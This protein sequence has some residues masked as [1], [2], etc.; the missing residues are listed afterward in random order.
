MLDEPTSNLDAQTALAINTTLRSLALNRTIIA[1][2]HDLSSVADADKI[3]VLQD[4]HL[5][6]EGIY[7]MLLMEE[8]VYNQL[9]Q[10]QG[11]AVQ[12]NGLVNGNIRPLSI[13]E[14]NGA[15]K[16]ATNSVT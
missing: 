14:G 10:S 13:T 16:C 9:W 15:S 7:E 5:V 8:G 11:F 1:I 4:G 2:T 3:F 6:E 12:G